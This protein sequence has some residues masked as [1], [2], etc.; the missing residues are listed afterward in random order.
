MRPYAAVGT[1]LVKLALADSCLKDAAAALSPVGPDRYCLP[2]HPAYCR[3]S[4][5]ELNGIT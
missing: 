2:R 3:P 1:T 4:F 5:L